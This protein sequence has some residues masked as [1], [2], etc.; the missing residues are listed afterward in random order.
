MTLKIGRNIN[1][2]DIAIVSS[3][4]ALN[5]VTSTKIAD[6]NPDRI[7]F[8]VSVDGIMGNSSI[9]IKLQAASAD[10]DIKGIWV[11]RQ[12]VVF[13]TDWSMPNDNIYTGEISAIIT[14]GMA[15]VFVTE[16]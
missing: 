3:S 9:F 13:K 12:G 6:A 7:A 2:N 5:A 16:Y 1:T 10:N 14:G 15:S 4:I 8:I 11:G